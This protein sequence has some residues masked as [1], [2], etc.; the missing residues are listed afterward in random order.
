MDES[1][2]SQFGGTGLGLA[3][4]RNLVNLLGGEI[5]IESTE[6]QG[7]TFYF[8]LPM[9]DNQAW[10]HNRQGGSGFRKEI[11]KDH[12]SYRPEDFNC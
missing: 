11:G 4:S 12:G 5:W 2:N 3:I 8:T 7:S 10:D 1:L 9:L 6:Q